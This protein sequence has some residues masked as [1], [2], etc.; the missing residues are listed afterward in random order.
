M[1]PTATNQQYHVTIRVLIDDARA[2]P[3]RAF[4][5]EN[6]DQIIRAESAADVA[7]A[8]SAMQAALDT[9]SYLAGFMSYELGYAL[10]SR[11]SGLMP[12]S[13]NVPLLWFG[14]FSDTG[15]LEGDDIESYLSS[16][17]TGPFEVS[18]PALTL[19]KVDYTTRFDAVKRYISEGDI[20]Q[21]N[22]TLKGHFSFQGDALA[23]YSELRRKQPVSYGA[24][25]EAEDFTVISASPELFIE[26][27]GSRI[28]TRPMK[29]TA[30]RALTLEQDQSTAGW[31]S[32][33][34]KSRAENLMIVDLMRNDIGRVSQTGSVMVSDLFTVETY[35]TL[36]QMTSGVEARLKP[37]TDVSTLLHSIFP[38]GSITGA[39]KVRAMEIIRELESE[40]RGIYTGAVGMFSPGNKACFNVA[41][42][43]LTL[44]EDGRGEVGIGSGVVHDS[45]AQAE[46]DECILK[47]RFLTEPMRDFQLIETML[48]DP[49]AGEYALLERHM[50]RLKASADYFL[51]PC[52]RVDIR[53]ALIER[54]KVLQDAPYRVRLLLFRDGH[55]EISQ[56]NIAGAATENMTFAVSDTRV[57][58][59]DKFLFHKTTERQLY[60]NEWARCHDEHGS[61]EVLFLNERAEVCEGSRTNIFLRSGGTL[62]TPALSCG[63]LP[64]TLREDLLAA[65]KAEEAVITL[66]DLANADVIYLGNSVRGLVEASELSVMATHSAV[67]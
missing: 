21:L 13:R 1:S 64:G 52:P 27:D 9:G 48:Y 62:L 14:V 42:R 33:D 24:Y 59:G 8:L 53:N 43:T 57:A 4:L 28:L 56:T 3:G 30:A 12:A 26:Q 31:L 45:Q 63:L 34:E 36:H 32:S 54:S 40:A 15:M 20:Y 41:I 5:F 38:P 50:E 39:P 25:I 10:E 60:D 51:F 29:G 35:E 17:I 65:G 19:N 46:Y 23:L 66:G 2:Q 7:D 49:E 47:M 37:D 44:F 16:N 11:L 61:D 18:E 58:S 22:L 6:P 67:S 55:F